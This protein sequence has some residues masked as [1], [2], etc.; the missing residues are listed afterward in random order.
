MNHA[1][2]MESS[3]DQKRV[4]FYMRASYGRERKAYEYLTQCGVHAYC[5]QQTV[6][7]DIN[8]KRKKIQASIIPNSLF[9]HS[10]EETMREYIGKLPTPYLHHYYKRQDGE[11]IPITIPDREMVMFRKWAET[12]ND[13]KYYRAK[14]YVFNHGE[15]VM[16]TQGMFEGFT[17]Q[18][19]SIKGYRR[20]GV[21]IE[22]VGFIATSY[23]PKSFLKSVKSDPLHASPE[24]RGA[25]E[26]L[27]LKQNR[28]NISP[29]P[30]LVGG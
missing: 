29:A 16:V 27:G 6:V 10:T 15:T 25:D 8:G 30:P 9:V 21:N 1:D 23:I 4:W 14:P 17:G 3:E 5:P 19:V 22:N 26:G 11:K 13:D 28:N 18:V 24:G 2:M 20:V 12:K 7:K